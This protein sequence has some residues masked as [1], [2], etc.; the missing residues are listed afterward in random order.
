MRTW[1][2]TVHAGGHPPDAREL[3]GE[4]RDVAVAVP[5]AVAAPA[6]RRWHT[7]WGASDDEV[8]APMP[9]DELVPRCQISWTRAITIDAPPGAVWP[10]LAQAG[11]GKAGFYSNDLLD[12]AAHPSAERVLPEF[13]RVRVG[14]WVP[15]FSR[16]DNSTAFKVQGFQPGR[17]LLWAKP[18]STWA[19]TLTPLPGGRTRLVTRIRQR[20]DWQ[21]PGAAVLTLVLMELA[22]FPMMRR[23]LK[24]IKE[25]AETPAE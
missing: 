17:F 2:T 20:Y 18:G 9:G 21:A 3:L 23:M 10:W 5:L 11:F 6:L 13:Q 25:R 16:V 1:G 22:D 15:M 4:L 8:A 14:N 24:G 7:R 19:W 12:N